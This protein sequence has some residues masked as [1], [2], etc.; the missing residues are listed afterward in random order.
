MGSREGGEVVV[1]PAGGGLQG[2]PTVSPGTLTPAYRRDSAT[3]W[4]GFTG[5]RWRIGLHGEIAIAK[6]TKALQGA[7]GDFLVAAPNVLGFPLSF[8]K[9]APNGPPARRGIRIH[10]LRIRTRHIE[11]QGTR[12]QARDGARD[13]LGE[14]YRTCEGIGVPRF[15]RRLRV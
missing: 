14:V 12:G 13:I 5:R 9:S 10:V 11:D 8:M 3:L 1:A 4:V 2:R 6:N 7:L 15:F